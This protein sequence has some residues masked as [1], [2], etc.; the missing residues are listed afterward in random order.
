M[1]ITKHNYEIFFIDYFDG[2]LTKSQEKELFLFLENNPELKNEFDNF[3]N[4][5]LIPQDEAT[6]DNKNI[7]RLI[8]ENAM[9]CITENENLCISDIEND[10]TELEKANFQLRLKNNSDLEKDYNLFKQTKLKA[11]TSIVFKHKNRIKRNVIPIG[12]VRTIMASAAA[13]LLFALVF[14]QIN[15]NDFSNKGA[16]LNNIDYGFSESKTAIVFQPN[17]TEQNLQTQ[18]NFNSQKIVNKHNNLVNNSETEQDSLHNAGFK[19]FPEINTKV[20]QRRIFVSENNSMQIAKV[21]ITKSTVTNT[22]EKKSIKE[23]INLWKIAESGVKT[24]NAVTSS[25][26]KLNNN[27]TEEG[28]IENVSFSY[29]RLKLNKS[30]NKNKY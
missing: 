12:M 16:A 13:I 18:N 22:T 30:F 24:W 4:I 25:N 28:E 6:F 21:T 10:I 26:V 9:F 23:Q 11:D 15:N 20:K 19:Q 1:K 5:Q 3:E 27:Y 17:T 7:L 29:K 14:T 8:P 2:S